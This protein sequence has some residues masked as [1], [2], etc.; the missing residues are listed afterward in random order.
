MAA[1]LG[2]TAWR[3]RS[4]GHLS[5]RSVMPGAGQV[6]SGSLIRNY[7]GFPGGISG[8]GLTTRAFE[9]A[10]SFGAIPS[11]AGPTTKLEPATDG[12]TLHL[13]GGQVQRRPQRPDHHRRVLPQARGPRPGLPARR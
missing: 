1:Q 8:T 7:L 4:T 12:F 10:W 6:G 2:I 5:Q 3:T 11:M 9:Q 13:A